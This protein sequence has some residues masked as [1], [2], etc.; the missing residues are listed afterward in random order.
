MIRHDEAS[1]KAVL[2]W[3]HELQ[4]DESTGARGDRAGVAKLRH[5]G[6]VLEASMQASTIDLC[7]RLGAAAAEMNDVA[8]IASVL[9]ELRKDDRSQTIARALGGQEPTSRVCAALRFQRLLQ[10]VG[11]DAQLTAFRRVLA[12]LKH[13]GHV[14][15]LAASLLDWNDPAR[16]DSR[17]Q[18]WLYDYY[19][20]ANPET[21]TRPEATP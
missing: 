2:A 15:D 14:A 6:S 11:A 19:H 12:L 17:R 16:R 9:A 18:R 20:T 1:V 13:A 8:L 4:P 3:W 7:R 21:A 10:A 5:A